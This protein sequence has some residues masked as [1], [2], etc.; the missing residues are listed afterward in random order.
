MPE[1]VARCHGR[2]HHRAVGLRPGV[3]LHVDVL[4]AIE[5]LGA[6]NG[7]FFG[8]VDVLAATV[9]AAAGVAFGIFVGQDRTLCFQHGTG[10]DVFRRN[11]LDLGLLAR[12]LLR[13]GCGQRIG[14]A[15]AGIPG[16]GGGNRR[17][18]E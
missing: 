9:V 6:F 3:R 8:N 16:R 10:D 11:Q 13:Q 14:V 18:S 2:Q 12:H 17:A 7:E 15:D 5:R 4:G 1:G